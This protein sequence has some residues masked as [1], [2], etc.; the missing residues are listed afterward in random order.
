MNPTD[1]ELEIAMLR[2]QVERAHDVIG[3]LRDALATIYAHC[4][5]DPQIAKLCDPLLTKYEPEYRS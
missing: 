1:R 3:E 4:G 2:D 5:E